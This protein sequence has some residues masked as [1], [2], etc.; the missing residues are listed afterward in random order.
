MDSSAL[1]SPDCKDVYVIKR[2]GNRQLINFQKVVKRLD[3]LRKMD[4]PL[5]VNVPMIAQK[6]I[7][8]IY[9]DVKT[10]ELDILASET[11]YYYNTTNLDYGK[12]AVRIEV[13]NMHKQTDDSL[14]TLSEKLYNH[15]NPVTKEHCP[16][17]SKSNL[18]FVKENESFLRFKIDYSRDYSYDYFGLKTLEKTYLKRINNVI[19]ERPQHMLMR[20]AIGIYKDIDNVLKTY[21][22]LSTGQ[23]THASPTLF[24]AGTP[25]PQMSSCFLMP[26]MED[27]LKGIYKTLSDCAEISKHGGGVGV[28]VTN[29][30]ASGSYIKSTDGK[31]NGL[32]PMLKVY[33]D[34]ARYVDQG[35]GNRKGAFAIYLEPWH[36]DVFEF[37][38][39]KKNQGNPDMRARDLF[40]ALWIPDL[41]MKRVESD[42]DWSLMCPHECPG[43]N[44][45]HGKTFEKLYEE[46]EQGGR[47]R[48]TIKAR[49]LWKHI[50]QCQIE[51][52]TPYMMYKDA[53]NAKSNQKNLGTIKGSNLCT[54]IVQYTS[55]D[56][57]AV[58]NLASIALPKCVT[59]SDDGKPYFNFFLLASITKHI[60]KSL[61]QVIDRNVYPTK[62]CRNSN[63]RHRPI[64][65]GVQGLADT[66]ALMRYPFCSDEARALNIKIFQ[67][68]YLA[69]VDESADEA[70]IYGSYESF[71]GSP[72]S[73]GLLQFDLWGIE[74]EDTIFN[75]D[76]VRGKAKCGM[77]NSLLVAPMPT[78]ST[79]SILGNNEAIEPFT[80]NIYARRVLAGEYICINKH[81]VKDLTDLGLWS[82]EMK[83]EIIKCKGSVQSIDAIPKDIKELYLTVWEM[84]MKHLC[85]MSRDRAPYIDQSESF[86]V[87]MKDPT[88]V[89]LTSMH[90]KRWNDGCKTGMYYLRTNAPSDAI[91]FTA[92]GGDNGKDGAVLQNNDASVCPLDCLSCSG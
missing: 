84:S 44:E 20:V 1:L 17:I 37:L 31:S 18:K 69:A 7:G 51:T 47:A 19:V 33:N 63:T 73:K 39:L 56:E 40:Y 3:I 58:C 25:C 62:E 34:T 45:V 4:P 8:G 6:V 13:S 22:L 16:L 64:G 15:V 71:K 67:T 12:L 60:V 86:N 35:G 9:N 43:L 21:E 61:N 23:Y 10:T 50:I 38:D 74:P 11:A 59:I 28:S 48:K 85:D 55:A 14:L 2:D 89:K 32:V 72:T 57:I 77:R 41:F 42:G 36:A 92:I 29:I 27:S 90:F 82:I 68:I 30:R 81:L 54:E 78:A 83:N 49:D 46:Y 26:I 75:V 91:Q 5:N 24:N 70:K 66:F 80:S 52:G 79:A 87:F 53:C 76:T 88:Y 65:V